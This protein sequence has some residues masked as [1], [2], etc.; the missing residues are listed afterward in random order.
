MTKLDS[1]GGAWREP[2]EEVQPNVEGVGRQQILDMK[3]T[4]LL[5][6]STKRGC[7]RVRAVDT[8]LEAYQKALNW[9]VGDAESGND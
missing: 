2:V 3:T 5:G 7:R 8:H 9:Q 6:R 1:E 4:E